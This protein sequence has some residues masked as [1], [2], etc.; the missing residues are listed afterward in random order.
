ME[1]RTDERARRVWEV[2]GNRQDAVVVLEDVHDP[3]NAQAVFRSCDAMG[4][5]FI[6]LVF[7]KQRPYD[8][9]RLGK[10]SSAT[11]H[12]WLDFQ[13][14]LSTRECVADLKADGYEVVAT[15]LQD[16]SESLFEVDLTAPKIAIMIGNE[17]RGLSDTA[18]EL[19]DRK[20]M[21]PMQGMVQSLNLSVTTA[22][23]LFEMTRQRTA[24]GTDY[25]L[26]KPVQEEIFAE[27]IK[28]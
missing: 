2:V 12:K 20:L 24:Q 22:L 11:A 7:V 27:L 17:H 16:D 10:A 21:V 3:H 18:V 13:T 25:S 4:V 19:A 14:Y 28:Q 23:C 5:H 8:P 6:K 26:D 9:L 1:F 15:V